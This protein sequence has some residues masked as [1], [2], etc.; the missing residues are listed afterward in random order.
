MLLNILQ[1]IGQPPTA[2][3]YLALRVNNAEDEK[4]GSR[5]NSSGVPAVFTL[6]FNLYSYESVHRVTWSCRQGKS[7]AAENGLKMR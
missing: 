3:S 2:N 7:L 6:A 5:G 4:H 1:C